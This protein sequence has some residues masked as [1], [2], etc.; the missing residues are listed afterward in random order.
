MRSDQVI[1]ERYT[2]TRMATEFPGG[3]TE[4]TKVA[5]LKT[6]GGQPPVGSNPTPSATRFPEDV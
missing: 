2:R 1:F 4:R 3:V 6:A 5:V